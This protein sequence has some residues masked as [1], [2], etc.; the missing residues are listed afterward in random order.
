MKS[1]WY[2]DKI[3]DLSQVLIDNFVG[4]DFDPGAWPAHRK[5]KSLNAFM[6]AHAANQKRIQIKNKIDALC[7]AGVREVKSYDC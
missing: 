4:D 7:G 2:F 6:R 1:F 3:A 5:D